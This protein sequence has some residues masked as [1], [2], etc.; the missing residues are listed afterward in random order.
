MISLEYELQ[1][2]LEVPCGINAKIKMPVVIGTI[3]LASFN[4]PEYFHMHTQEGQSNGRLTPPPSYMEAMS[5]RSLDGTGQMQ[6]PSQERVKPT[7]PPFVYLALT[8]T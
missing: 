6:K 3:P 4:G 5:Y 8:A 1:F 7:A 2:Q